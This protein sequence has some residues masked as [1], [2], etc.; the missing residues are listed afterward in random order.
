M[1]SLGATANTPARRRSIAVFAALALLVGMVLPVLRA[2]RAR[3]DE[4]P[5][6]VTV[7]D[8]TVTEGNS[9][10]S[11]NFTISL[12][13]PPLVDDVIVNWHT[14]DVTATSPQDYV[15]QSDTETFETGTLS[16][17][18]SIPIIG[19]TFPEIDETFQVVATIDGENTDAIGTMT[20]DADGDGDP[21]GLSVND[22]SLSEGDGG[23]SG[24]TRPFTFTVT[25][26]A[27]NQ[28]NV[29]FR[30]STT[31]GTATQG[32]DYSG[33]TNNVGTI[34][35][36]SL[37]TNV[38][39]QVIGDTAVELNETFTVTL[40]QPSNA[41]IDDANGTG[42]ILDDD[43]PAMSF[44]T[45]PET[46]TEGASADAT[47]TFTV[48]L[49]TASG[50]TVT[51]NYATTA[52]TATAGADYTS[53]SGTV[54][55]PANDTS[56][57]I[58]VTVKHD[59]LDEDTE[60]FDLTLTGEHNAT[61]TATSCAAGGEITDNDGAPTLTVD[62][63]TVTEPDT[64]SVDASFTVRLSAASGQLVT[65]NYA[66]NAG[67]AT[68]GTDYTH[69]TGV[70]QFDP[71]QTSKTVT[72]PVLGDTDAEGHEKF[73]LVATP[74]DS[75]STCGTTTTTDCTGDGTILDD[76]TATVTIDNPSAPEGNIPGQTITFT[77]TLSEDIS[78]PVNI[79]YET[80]DG[81]ATE[82]E[83]YQADSGTVTI[84]AGDD[85]E[86][87]VID[88]VS[89]VTPEPA[90][91][92]FVTLS[93]PDTAVIADGEG[94]GEI[95][96]SDAGTAPT[97]SVDD[98]EVVENAGPMTFVVTRGGG[99]TTR[100]VRADYNVT[101]GTA[102]A[103]DYTATS[104][105]IE[106]DPTETSANITV[107]VN[108]DAIDEVDETLT[109]T[110]SNPSNA[111]LADATGTG[112]IDDDDGPQITITDETVTEGNAGTKITEFTLALTQSSPQV[113]SVDW[114]TADD[115][116][117]TS[118]AG[119]HDY[120]ADDGTVTFPANSAADQTVTI[121]VNSDTRDEVDE[122]FGVEL[123]NPVDAT[124]GDPD[125]AGTGTVVDDDGPT[126]SIDDISVTEG[127]SGTV[128]A[129]F[130][131][132]LSDASPQTVTVNYTTVDNTATVGDNDY[133]A[134]A[135]TLTF[136]P[137]T[138]TANVTV[139]VKGDTRNETDET[140]KVTL[141]GAQ[142]AT[143]AKADGVGTITNDDPE[144][145]I[146]IG[147]APVTEGDDE[148]V[149]A[150]FEVTLSDVSGRTVTVNY[151]TDDGDAVADNDYLST[152]GTVTFNPGIKTQRIE[153]TVLGDNEVEDDESFFV[154]LSDPTNAEL[155]NSTGEGVIENDDSDDGTPPPG[156]GGEEEAEPEQGYW[157]TA[158]DGGL[159][160]YG[161]SKFFGSQ[162]GKPLNQPVVD[163]APT[164]TGRG[165]WQVASD[166]GIF[167]YGDA[168]M[169]GSMGGQPLN[170][171][172]VGMAAVPDAQ[173]YWLVASDGGIFSFGA[174]ATRFYG[175]MGG[176]PLNKP[177]VGMAVTPTG[178]GYWLVASDGGI[179]SFGDA[180]M[181]GSMGGQPLNSPIVGMAATPDAQ[182]YWLVAA[183]GGIF[184][185]GAA[186]SRFD[187]SLG[188][189]PLD[190]PVVDMASTPT[191]QGYWIVGADGLVATFG[192]AEPLGSM[193]GQPLNKPIVGMAAFPG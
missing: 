116:A 84:A 37:S 19:D 125:E 98:P 186:A 170:Q 34:P 65:V 175:S 97:L 133:T 118:V 129:V 153:V 46:L 138:T 109:V 139:K 91:N 53:A 56:E 24:G 128:D 92:F 178:R 120:V 18:L 64:G 182:G 39:V 11:L 166:G 176:Q 79:D 180:T 68:A 72:V 70:L 157:L 48:T 127:L 13:V 100:T 57:D 80:S 114:E 148:N 85:D 60:R 31:A 99:T 134:Q 106:I 163:M 101:N 123:S 20:I 8:E 155:N 192:D 69:T 77:V 112:T 140:F 104:G 131:V 159:F 179:F 191:G 121:T 55:F 52:D 160:S 172:V 22:I 115:T 130:P 74:T 119:E 137:T 187:G 12:D 62:D 142:K 102:G 105:T 193:E 162:G 71:G 86:T 161:E 150:T 96:D 169:H 32:G 132:T 40:S 10:K 76:E 185:F 136:A 188:G 88:L 164:P 144:P 63:A 5:R 149:P 168:T 50:R 103:G 111:T 66:T 124:I 49:A 54:T 126:I 143:I 15:P 61:C 7:S 36:G 90:E 184:S 174:A 14:V 190:A 35:A 108:D 2:D 75:T 27:V 95:T 87:I 122:Q 156:G 23:T 154:D 4:V 1:T 16:K 47:M 9:N 113:V 107:A 42:T 189:I 3:A 181:H 183:D 110:L 165:Y 146:F 38:V 83:D 117:T 30:W 141:S 147:D 78:Q 45:N 177:I 89:D 17:Q 33:V 135:G 152:S 25:Q 29:A 21:P 81:S 59:T 26:S 171:P 58:N 167:S 158:T 151:A 67:S 44:S 28:Q 41:K 43:A 82:G 173:G 6:T 93:N 73:T 145:S 94:E 51:A